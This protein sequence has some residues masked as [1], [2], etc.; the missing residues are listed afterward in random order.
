MILKDVVTENCYKF[1]YS[2]SDPRMEVHP[3]DNTKIIF[4]FSERYQTDLMKFLRASFGDNM[5]SLENKRNMVES[6]V[7]IGHSWI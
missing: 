5:P 2:V 3:K 7:Q 1:E 6:R 4:R